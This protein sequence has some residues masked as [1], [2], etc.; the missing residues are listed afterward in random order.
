MSLIS[1]SKTAKFLALPILLP[2]NKPTDPPESDT[3]VLLNLPLLANK[4]LPSR[5]SEII[6]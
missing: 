2:S 1:N 5:V 4:I 6:I 3:L